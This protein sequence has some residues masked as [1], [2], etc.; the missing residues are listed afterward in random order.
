MPG[1]GVDLIVQ[2]VGSPGKLSTFCWVLLELS[3]G[4]LHSC[5]GG[6]EADEWPCLI[7]HSHRVV[8][9]HFLSREKNKAVYTGVHRCMAVA[10]TLPFV[11]HP[12]PHSH[13][14][15]V[16]IPLPPP[17]PPT[18]R[19]RHWAECNSRRCFW[20]F[21]ELELGFNRAL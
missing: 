11:I 8:R 6:G 1:P 7:F 2:A 19:W 21:S 5:A 9:C 16:Y 20:A 14:S 13:I 4:S 10:H 3:K 17:P 15:G 18:H 12:L